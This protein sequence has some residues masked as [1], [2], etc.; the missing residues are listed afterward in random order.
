MITFSKENLLTFFLRETGAKGRFVLG[1]TVA[2]GLLQAGLISVLAFW[3]G[4][5]SGHQALPVAIGFIAGALLLLAGDHF[6]LRRVSELSERAIGNV[7]LRLTARA[8]A[9]EL[10]ELER[11]G[12]QRLLDLT[13]RD[14]ATVSAHQRAAFA[15]I[16]NVVLAVALVIVLLS[17]APLIG[18]LMILTSVAFAKAPALRRIAAE[19]ARASSVER[20]LL[21]LSRSAISGFKELRLDGDKCADFFDNALRPAVEQTVSPRICL[22]RLTVRVAAVETATFY[23]VAAL[24]AFCAPFL[25]FGP[26]AAATTFLVLCAT[27]PIT[28]LISTVAD[29]AAG[30]SAVQNLYQL[31]R[32]LVRAEAPPPASPIR[33]RRFASLRLEA[34]CFTYPGSRSER[35]SGIGPVDLQLVPGTI[36]FLAGGNGSGKSTLLKLVTGLYPL[37]AGRLLLDGTEADCGTVRELFSGVFTDFHLFDRL[38]GADQIDP[39]RME[40]LLHG[41]GLAGKTRL[42]DGAFTTTDLST[43]QRK[44]LA[45]LIAIL[46]D[47]P[48]YVF[49]EWAADQDPAF[50]R[51]FYK[52]LLPGLKLAGKA[53]IAATHDDRYFDLCDRLIIMEGGRMVTPA[54]PILFAERSPI[55]ER[56]P[57]R[58][59]TLVN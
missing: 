22:R 45:L 14:L 41:L 18:T 53:I 31:E 58:E 30:N 13:A 7:T 48:V 35:P 47:R 19:E 59:R 28:D 3:L 11:I 1:L 2:C 5:A 33:R 29:L 36:T 37:S 49:D 10:L 54:A 4:K 9:I 27:Y 52:T 20:R 55:A 25:G 42:F 21:G 51:L 56:I 15:G 17:V 26:A 50:R 39:A 8:R 12:P 34:A 46:E 57:V 40:G 43:G 24:A 38:Y 6:A 23:I 44:R 16:E 32:E